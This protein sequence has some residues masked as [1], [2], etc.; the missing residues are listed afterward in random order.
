MHQWRTDL[1]STEIYVQIIRRGSQFHIDED[2][3]RL[4]V[5]VTKQLKIEAS[6]L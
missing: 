1:I 2:K 6:R 4:E 3:A 5:L